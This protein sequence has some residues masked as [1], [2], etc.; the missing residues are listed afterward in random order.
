MQ[1]LRAEKFKNKKIYNEKK[2]QKRE[3]K[4]KILP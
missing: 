2:T 3:E 4:R 1:L